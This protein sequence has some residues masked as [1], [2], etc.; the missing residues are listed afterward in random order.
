MMP[1][2]APRRGGEGRAAAACVWRWRGARPQT[3]RRSAPEPRAPRRPSRARAGDCARAIARARCCAYSLFRCARAL[4]GPA[5]GGRADRRVRLPGL[6]LKM[7][8]EKACAAT[9]HKVNSSVGVVP[10]YLCLSGRTLS[11]PRTVPG[12]V[13]VCVWP[14]SRWCGAGRSTGT[15]RQETLHIFR[16]G[17][18]RESGTEGSSPRRT[19]PHSVSRKRLA[20]YRE[21]HGTD[22]PGVNFCYLRRGPTGYGGGNPGGR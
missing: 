18:L 11:S 5:C 19:R 13:S 9:K 15:H 14:A 1:R 3:R 10:A 17:G 6:E 12:N 4:G 16:P 8:T 2:V 21:R 20:V 7:L 22:R